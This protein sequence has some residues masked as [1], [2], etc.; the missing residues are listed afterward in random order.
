MLRQRHRAEAA[1]AGRPAGGKLDTERQPLDRVFRPRSVAVVGASPRERSVGRAVCQ[2]LL[3]GSFSG[4]LR[5]VNPRHTEV[6]GHPCLASVSELPEAPDLAIIATPAAT[7]ADVASELAGIGTGAAVV[8]TAGIDAAGNSR[9][10]AIVA[11]SGMRIVGPNCLGVLSPSIGLNASFSHLAAQAGRLAFISQSGAILTSVLDWAVAGGIGFSAMVSIGNAL[12]V[13]LGDLIDHFASDRETSAIL[14][15][16]ESVQDAALFMSAARRAA[17]TK[18]VI[19]MK[20]GRYPEGA[21]AALSHTGALAGSDAVY[22]AAFRRA[23]IVRVLSL[24]ELFD[25]AEILSLERP[26]TG[27]AL[28]IVTNGG[29]AGV[30][31]ADC[32]HETAGHLSAITEDTKNALDAVL[33]KT[34]SR[35]NPI[36]IIG[37]A[38]GA[39]YRDALKIVLDD[40]GNHAVLVIRCPTSIASSE[41]TARAVIDA[42]AEHRKAGT[43]QKP[44]LTCWLGE[45]TAGAA[46]HLFGQARIA[47]FESPEDAVRALMH[48]ISLA[49]VRETMMSMPRLSQQDFA[50]DRQAAQAVIAPVRQDGRTL[51]MEAESKAL[52]AAYGLRVAETVVARTPEEAGGLVAQMMSAPHAPAACVLKIVSPDITHKSDV[53]GVRL[54]IR[55]AEE[56]RSAAADLLRA[57]GERQPEARLLGIAVQPMIDRKGAHE[58]IAGIARDAAFGPVILFGA[59][60]T[61]VEVVDDKA[62][63]LPPLDDLLAKAM[64]SRTRVARLLAGYRHRP[65]ANLDAISE[66]LIRLARMAEDLPEIAELDINPLLA[67]ADGV[68]AL[69]ARVVLTD[70]KRR[71]AGGADHLAI[72]PYP[73]GWREDFRDREGRLVHLRPILPTDERLYPE[74]FEKVTERDIRFRLFAPRRNFSHADFARWTQIDYRREMAFVAIADRSGDLLGVSRLVRDAHGEAAEFAVLVRSDMQGRGIGFALMRRLIDYARARSVKALHGEVLR[75]NSC[76]RALCRALGGRETA[77]PDGSDSIIAELDLTGAG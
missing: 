22:Q 77:A 64:I 36:D 61:A 72:A 33:P 21:K 35:A 11:E 1:R 66:T 29:G 8:L 62:I 26:F 55:S 59:G 34:W 49:R 70:P 73:E 38:D 25:A 28:T 23:G 67:D 39:R 19:V 53:G 68:I 24:E 71:I 12:D 14:L 41:E 44:V 45:A 17:R 4:A 20:A 9:L 18:P 51:L 16:V 52:L 54:D 10:K 65:P 5:F 58:L 57:V 7:V 3:A 74:F 6:L 37:D 27:E 60:G 69:D 40:P 46:R 42:V 2:N 15:Y 76:M 56:A 32:L 50:V 31:A 30:I 47:T 75:E 43:K 13:R 48:M 63:D